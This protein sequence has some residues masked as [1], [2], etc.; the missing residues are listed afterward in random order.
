M[1]NSVGVVDK[2]IAMVDSTITKPIRPS[3]LY[4]SLVELFLGPSRDDA[5]RKLPAAPDPVRDSEHRRRKG[6]RI[7]CVD[8][9]GVNRTII[10]QQ[11][12]ALGYTAIVVEDA[13]QALSALS[14]EK[15]DIVLMD[16]EMPGMDGYQATAEIRRREGS[17]AHTIVIALTAHATEGDRELCM[18]AGMDGYVSK[19]VKMKA[20]ASALDEWTHR[21]ARGGNR[22]GPTAGRPADAGNYDEQL[23]P[24]SLA[25][26]AELGDDLLGKL[27]EDFLSDFDGRLASM[28][29]ALD[30]RDLRLLA[31]IAHF[32]KSASATL[33]A[34]RFSALC[35]QVEARALAGDADEAI[36][37]GR[38]LIT[39]AHALPALLARAADNSARPHIH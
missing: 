26:I 28:E 20:L 4:G 23:D 3:D 25:E 36:S 32:F 9:N 29:D 13:T 27:V 22:S 33:G 18:S 37:S 35:A 34:K 16:C 10:G 17:S 30:A 11:L 14:R 21:G 24:A 31:S 15:F 12:A 2:S 38:S 8:D 7:L 39:A 19:P 1:L 5:V 6:V